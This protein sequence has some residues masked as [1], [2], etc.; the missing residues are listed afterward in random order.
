M[1]S[2]R[3][4]AGRVSVSIACKVVDMLTRDPAEK[5]LL[6]MERVLFDWNTND[7]HCS[8]NVCA[9]TVNVNSERK[10]ILFLKTL[11]IVVMGE[12][13]N[14]QGKIY[15]RQCIITCHSHLLFYIES[16]L[17]SSIAMQPRT[18][19]SQRI[20][21]SSVFMRV[22]SCSHCKR[23]ASPYRNDRTAIIEFGCR[24]WL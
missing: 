20:N 5:K 18:I 15:E 16:Y 4:K 8:L 3:Q 17:R 6:A 24:G 11:A 21:Y 13:L 23:K 22:P 14:S 12:Y 1:S 19:I 9:C 2:T 7:E 10:G